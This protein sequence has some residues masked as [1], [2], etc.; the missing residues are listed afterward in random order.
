MGAVSPEPEGIVV[1]VDGGGSKTDVA[2]VEP[3]SG[4]VLGSHRGPGCS[5]H[6]IGVDRAV[7]VVDST[8]RSALAHAG[9]A[10]QDV[11]HAGCYLTAVDLPEESRLLA[12]RLGRLP[13]AARSVVVENDVFAL[14]RAGTEAAD[15]AVV[16]CGTGVNGAAVR[17]DGRTARILALGRL[18]GDWG[19]AS[20]IAE[21][22]LWHAARAED[23]RG[24]PTALREAL[25]DWTGYQTVHDLIVALHRGETDISTWWSR[26]PDLFALAAT[27]DPVAAS[28]VDR[29]GRE[30][31]RLA[32][33]L[34]SRLDLAAS[35]VPV[36][37]GGGIGASGD[38]LLMAAI[39]DEL[40]LQAPGATPAVTTAPPVQGAIL[41]AR[42]A[43]PAEAQAAESR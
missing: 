7:A 25:L 43:V 24:R 2:V 38:P 39:R 10:P 6:L 31:G 41:L 4:T 36:V 33:A 11:A 1:A 18:S 35:D 22:V 12:D 8:V 32:A 34:L 20:G 19:G 21:D 42:N 16:V 5:H 17:A 23:G 14:L 37:L 9:V 28:L 27:G 15:A 30:I 26:M 40:R 29:Q 3:V 13:W